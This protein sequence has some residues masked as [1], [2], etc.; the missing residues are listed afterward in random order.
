MAVL[1]A[2]LILVDLT[3]L[4]TRAGPHASA[5]IMQWAIMTM[6]LL[7]VPTTVALLRYAELIPGRKPSTL[8]NLVA[9][10]SARKAARK[11]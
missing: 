10:A 9:Q 6:L 7:T 2:V 8:A 5:L 3:G 11:A 4:I 1:S